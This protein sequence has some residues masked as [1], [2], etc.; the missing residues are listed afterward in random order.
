MTDRIAF[1]T[2]VLEGVLKT[3]HPILGFIWY[4]RRFSLCADSSFRRYNGDQLRYFQIILPSTTVRKEADTDFIV[5]LNLPSA[6]SFEHRFHIR[7]E[8]A[9]ERDRWVDT[10]SQMIASE[11][12]K[13]RSIQAKFGQPGLTFL[14][15][16]NII[17]HPNGACHTLDDLRGHDIVGIYLSAKWCG[18]CQAFTKQLSQLYKELVRADKRFGVLFVSN[19]DFDEKSFTECVSSPL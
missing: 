17:S 3:R 11:T 5:C 16:A 13:E 7:A 12:H 10:I 6:A 15:E 18:P 4:T 14:E 9:A 2:V 19:N 1:Q 8:S